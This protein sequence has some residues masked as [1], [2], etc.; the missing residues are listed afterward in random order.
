MGKTLTTDLLQC[1]GIPVADTDRIAREIVEPGAPLLVELTERFGPTILTP[2]GEL[3]RR[4]MANLVFSDPIARR[5]LEALMHPA[6][7]EIWKRQV[8]VWRSAGRDAGV[9]VIP[10]LFETGEEGEVDAAICVACTAATQ[11]GRLHGRGWSDQEI[12]RRIAAQM[13]IEEKMRRSDFVIWNEGDQGC[14]KDQLRR[15]I[16]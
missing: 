14:L 1:F 12:D 3:D 13:P 4:T 8:A 11:R 6:I 16:P 7:R 2:G 10:L 15:I 5:D 9:L